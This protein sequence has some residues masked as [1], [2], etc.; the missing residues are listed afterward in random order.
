VEIRF[1]RSKFGE[2][3]PKKNRKKKKEKTLARRP[4]FNSTTELGFGKPHALVILSFFVCVVLCFS[5]QFG[6]MCACDD[7]D[8]EE[9]P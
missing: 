8:W 3:S 4:P 7:H 2:V 1:F 6:C 9:E 5:L